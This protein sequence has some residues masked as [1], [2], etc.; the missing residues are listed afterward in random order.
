MNPNTLKIRTLGQVHVQLGDQEA[1]FHSEPARALLFYLL[2]FVEGRSKSE[3]L[4]DLWDEE[5]SPAVN[6]RFRVTLHRIRTALGV[7]DGVHEQYGRYQISREVLQSSDLFHFYTH[8]SQ[9]EHLTGQPRLKELQKALSYYTGNYLEGMDQEW[10]QQ[11]RE[12][13][14]TAYV[15]ALLEL[16]ML[17]CTEGQCEDTVH[18]LFRALKADPFIGENYHQKLMTCLSVVEDRY[19]AIEHYR[20]FIHFL[21]NELQDTPMKDTVSLA[22]RIKDGEAICKRK[23]EGDAQEASMTSNC[24]F[25]PSG[26]CPEFFLD[27]SESRTDV[28]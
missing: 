26:Q 4:H 28:N 14:R 9:A 16:S 3:I 13:H 8:L 25:T 1:Q 5:E 24:P 2:S 20:R 12:E 15:R 19:A 17:Y 18:A 22:Q 7:S 21:K 10:V 6:N 11:A 23:H 27:L